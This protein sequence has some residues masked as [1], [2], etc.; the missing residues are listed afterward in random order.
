MKKKFETNV[1]KRNWNNDLIILKYI[2]INCG[3]IILQTFHVHNK[4][5]I[6]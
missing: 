4:E 1:V 2:K 6:E 3:Q 5:I